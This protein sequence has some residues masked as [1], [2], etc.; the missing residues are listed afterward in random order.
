MPLA[1]LFLALGTLS[2]TPNEAQ[3][4]GR[5][6]RGG[7]PTGETWSIK[8]GGGFETTLRA[9]N[10][11]FI[12]RRGRWKYERGL[13]TSTLTVETETGKPRDFRIAKAGGEIC[14]EVDPEKQIIFVKFEEYREPQTILDYVPPPR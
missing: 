3:I 9:P 1:L 12:G 11:E 10:G 5:Y 7:D 4:T 2:C 13:L 6:L 14:I 8:P